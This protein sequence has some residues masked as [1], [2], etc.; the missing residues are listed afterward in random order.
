[1]RCLHLKI[2]LNSVDQQIHLINELLEISRFEAGKENLHFETRNIKPIIEN[3]IKEF[4]P[5]IENIDGKIS[6]ETRGKS[7]KV[8]FDKENSPI[9]Q[10]HISSLKE[11]CLS[12]YLVIQ[13]WIDYSNGIGD[14]TSEFFRDLPVKY[15]D[16][17]EIAKARV[18]RRL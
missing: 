13:K 1:M 16:I 10:S 15:T 18:K 6:F 11:F 2:I 5:I 3:T 4:K 17:M 12:D 14:P 9:Q 7:K 8:E